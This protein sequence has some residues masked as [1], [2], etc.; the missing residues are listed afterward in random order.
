M[1]ICSGSQYLVLLYQAEYFLVDWLGPHQELLQAILRNSTDVGS[2]L[3]EVA[4]VKHHPLVVVA[5]ITRFK[6]PYR[7]VMMISLCVFSF[8]LLTASLGASSSR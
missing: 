6:E 3:V 7:S 1:L 5:F 8:R 2:P 4:I